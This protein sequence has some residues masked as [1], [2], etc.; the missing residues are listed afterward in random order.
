[1][2]VHHPCTVTAPRCRSWL[3]PRGRA[4]LPTFA[5]SPVRCRRIAGMARRNAHPAQARSDAHEAPRQAV[6]GLMVRDVST[7]AGDNRA[8]RQ[9]VRPCATTRQVRPLRNIADL[10][11]SR[12][13][14]VSKSLT[15]SAL[16]LPLKELPGRL[17]DMKHPAF[18]ETWFRLLCGLSVQALLGPWEHHVKYLRTLTKP[19]DHLAALWNEKLSDVLDETILPWTAARKDGYDWTLHHRFLIDFEKFRRLVGAGYPDRLLQLAKTNGDEGHSFP[20]LAKDGFEPNTGYRP[21]AQASLKHLSCLLARELWRLG[22]A[23]GT[24]LSRSA[25]FLSRHS[26]RACT[27]F[28]LMTVEKNPAD[29]EKRLEEVE[30]IVRVITEHPDPLVRETLDHW[31]DA[32][33]LA[34]AT[35]GDFRESVRR[36]MKLGRPPLDENVGSEIDTAFDRLAVW[37]ANESAERN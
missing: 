21:A 30:G 17:G 26:F 12:F 8:P 10:P 13:P 37:R 19:K 28:G 1:M 32:P 11:S 31:R 29:L 34:Y 25:F 27:E 14:G 20:R 23:R 3:R 16:R 4:A 2:S 35:D 15:R 33:F 9:A 6:R 18:D 24:V 22:V 36:E 5:P 7:Q